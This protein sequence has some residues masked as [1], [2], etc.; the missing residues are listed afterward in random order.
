KAYQR[1]LVDGKAKFHVRAS[2]SGLPFAVEIDSVYICKS[3]LDKLKQ[4]DNLKRQDRELLAILKGLVTSS[5]RVLET[6]ESSL[7][8]SPPESL[9]RVNIA[10]R[11]CIESTFR[12]FVAPL[13]PVSVQ[14][15]C[16]SSIPSVE[17]PS[18]PRDSSV[19]HHS[20][21]SKQ[22]DT[23]PTSSRQSGVVTVKLQWSND[24]NERDLPDDLQSLGKMLVH[25][26]YKQIANAAW[27]SAALRKQLQ[28]VALIKQID[29]EC[30]G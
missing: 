8:S 23:F 28:I 29:S 13:S 24:K 10:K 26:T 22:P 7:A 20:T 12:P 25:G 11:P 9:E 19:V 14:T 17:S 18:S 3:C 4:L 15:G 1:Y 16:W 21:P 2:L 6:R 27:K 30:N 5:K